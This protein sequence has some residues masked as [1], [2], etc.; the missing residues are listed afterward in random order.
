MYLYAL[1]RKS[2]PAK[3]GLKISCTGPSD[4]M[5]DEF[6]VW[7]DTCMISLN[8]TNYRVRSFKISSRT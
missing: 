3:S 7:L 6:E 5:S 1:S 8:D 4:K 2:V